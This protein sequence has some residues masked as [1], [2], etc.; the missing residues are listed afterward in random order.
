MDA[1]VLVSLVKPSGRRWP[2]EG[3]IVTRLAQLRGGGWCWAAQAAE[4]TGADEVAC[5]RALKS[6]EERKIIKRDPGDGPRPD[7]IRWC[8]VSEDWRRWRAEWLLDP[9]QIAAQLALAAQQRDE[10]PFTRIFARSYSARSVGRIA[11]SYDAR[12]WVED[13]EEVA[14][15]ARYRNARSQTVDNSDRA[16]CIARSLGRRRAILERAILGVSALGSSLPGV[17]DT[18]PPPSGPSPRQEERVVAVEV[19]QLKARIV[20]AAV[21]APGHTAA[22]L[23]GPPLWQLVGLVDEHGLSVVEAAFARVAPGTL[24]PVRIVE[25]LAD[26]VLVAAGDPVHGSALSQDPAAAVKHLERLIASYDGAAV[27]ETLLAELARCQTD[28]DARQEAPA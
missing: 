16:L 3:A 14:G 10:S 24:S 8:A 19:K 28:L 20:A 2:L 15:I 17:A 22:F 27:P 5:R 9:S 23:N 13:L 12:S 18:K 1:M 7:H 25:L 6:L 26:L 4:W 11:R 21:P